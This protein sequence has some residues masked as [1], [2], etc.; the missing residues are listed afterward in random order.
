MLVQT[1]IDVIFFITKFN[2]VPEL[3]V[4]ECSMES[5]IAQEF[6]KLIYLQLFLVQVR[7]RTE[8]LS[9]PSSTRLGFELM[10][11]RS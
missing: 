4:V 8:I 1:S 3:H 10:I 6:Q 5:S 7:L 9:T 2:Y 11:S